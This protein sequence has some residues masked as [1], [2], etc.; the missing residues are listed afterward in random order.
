MSSGEIEDKIADQSGIELL[1][2]D[3]NDDD[4]HTKKSDVGSY[5]S[6]GSL[7]SSS[8]DD[9]DAGGKA[10]GAKGKRK[11]R[12]PLIQVSIIILFSGY[13]IVSNLISNCIDNL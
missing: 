10:G 7:S 1:P 13:Y 3:L 12:V 8:I 11:P 2:L 9:I 6:D 5:H 4:E